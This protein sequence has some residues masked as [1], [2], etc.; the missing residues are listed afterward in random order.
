M[1]K[2]FQQALAVARAKRGEDHPNVAAT[3]GN[4]ATV[5]EADSR[6]TEA[7]DAYKKTRA[8]FEKLYGRSHPLTAIGLNNLA[9]VYADQNRM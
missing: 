9:N 2:R 8:V 4:L 3:I 5:L 1:R 6:F 7:E